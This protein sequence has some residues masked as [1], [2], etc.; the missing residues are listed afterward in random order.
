VVTGNSDERV[1]GMLVTRVEGKERRNAQGVTDLAYADDVTTRA[2]GCITT[3]VGKPDKKRAWVTHAE[4]TAALSGLDPKNA[5]VKAQRKSPNILHPGDIVYFARAKREGL[6]LQKGTTNTYKAK[7]PKMSVALTFNNHKGPLANEPYV[8]E[9]LG[10]HE[11][12][13]TDG[14]GKLTIHVPVHLREVHVAFPGQ[15]IGYPVRIG[16]IDPIDEPA[17]VRERL[18]HLGHHAP[19]AGEISEDDLDERDRR[20]IAAFQEVHGLHITCVWPG[21]GLND[22]G[23]PDFLQPW[24]AIV[25]LVLQIRNS[26]A[27]RVKTTA[28]PEGKAGVTM[29]PSPTVAEVYLDGGFPAELLANNIMHEFMHLKLDT[30]Q[31]I[32][33]V[34]V[35][36]PECRSGRIWTAV[37]ADFRHP[38]SSPVRGSFEKE[39]D[40]P[41]KRP[42]SVSQQHPRR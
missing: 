27:S 30:G 35:H 23:P 5:A 8:V 36:G 9:G 4:G 37:R 7:V 17:G 33:P 10:E 21:C 29:G 25:S 41:R 39:Q 18:Q 1:S 42:R 34:T 22:L 16:D 2:E 6:A 38:C 14:A 3:L 12:G 32:V 20:S 13:S 19:P 24:D 40:H 28:V 26:V 31:S 11:E 15:S